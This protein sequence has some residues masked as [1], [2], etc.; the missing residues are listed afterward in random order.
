MKVIK[1]VPSTEIAGTGVSLLADSALLKDGKPFFIPDFSDRFTAIPALVIHINRL[2]KNIARKFAHRYYDAVGIGVCITAEPLYDS[3]LQ[4]GL[5][6][7]IAFSFDG[8]AILGDFLDV[9]QFQVEAEI[10]EAHF[11]VGGNLQW[12]FKISDLYVYV[13]S[14]IEYLSK[15]YT[16]KI[17]DYLYITHPQ[18]QHLVLE[19]DMHLTG[20]INAVSLLSMRIK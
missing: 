5:P 13:D 14:L 6:A 15:F 7:D 3:L 4:K 19:R 12:Q 9:G 17:G 11:E 8:A 20:G 18:A 10:A 1:I 2:G 16:M